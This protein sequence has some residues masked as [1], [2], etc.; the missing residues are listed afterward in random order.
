MRLVYAAARASAEEQRVATRRLA[1]GLAAILLCAGGG[2]GSG[3]RDAPT[4]GR[5]AEGDLSWAREPRLVAPKTLP[6]DRILVG[7]VRND[8]LRPVAVSAANVRVLD[9]GG[10]RLQASAVF[11]ASY[12][13][14]LYP[15]TREP[16]QLPEEELRRTG[17]KAVIAPGKSAPLTVSWRRRTGPGAATRVDLGGAALPMPG[18]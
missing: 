11:L 10:D 14:G 13:H 18:S 17:R 4:A 3:D 12:V 2:C 15:P 16:E 5:P 1:A 9:S 6:R 8:S 7:R